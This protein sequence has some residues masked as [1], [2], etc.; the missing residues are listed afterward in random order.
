VGQLRLAHPFFVSGTPMSRRKWGLVAGTLLAVGVVVGLVW[1]VNKKP[2]PP[3]LDTGPFAFDGPS[4]QLKSTVIVPTLD[5]P[6]EPGK[7]IVWCASFALAWKQAE[8]KIAIGPVQ[9]PGA[10]SVADRLNADQSAE[11]DLPPGSVFADAGFLEDGILERIRTGMAERFPKRPLPEFAVPAGGAVAFAHLEV[12]SK[13]EY[14]YFEYEKSQSFYSSDKSTHKVRAFGI[15]GEEAFKQG[16]VPKLRKQV[17]VLYRQGEPDRPWDAV[18]Y[19]LDLN[20]TDKRDQIIVALVERKATLAEQLAD[21]NEKMAAHKRA[22]EHEKHIHT[23]DTVLVPNVGFRVTHRF[24]ELEVDPIKEAFQ[25]TQF[26]LNRSGADLKS[27]A[28]ILIKPEPMDYSFDRPF[29]VVMKRRDR[30]RPYFVAWIDNA[31]LLEK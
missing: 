16:D 3:P 30:D 7:N 11:D 10:Q 23:N 13:F 9:L 21:L 12:S 18:A 2:A 25:M 1:W 6:T 26:R 19:A 28:G 14:P 24:R 22:E 27:E 31:E 17:A 8:K 15:R 4:E 20:I 5:T 29:L